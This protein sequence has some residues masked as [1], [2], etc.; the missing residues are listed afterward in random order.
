[1]ILSINEYNERLESGEESNGYTLYLTRDYVLV[2]HKYAMDG[3]CLASMA[4]THRNVIEYESKKRAIANA[5]IVTTPFEVYIVSICEI[6][7]NVEILVPY[8][9]RYEMRR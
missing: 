8:G 9:N 4:N 6:N 1:M 7:A 5:K 2:C 3:T